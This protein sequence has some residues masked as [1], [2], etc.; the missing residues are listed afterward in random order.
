MIFKINKM[1]YE[2]M[3][4]FV[5]YQVYNALSAPSHRARAYGIKGLIR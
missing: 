1:I 4:I 3:F 5:S 2:I